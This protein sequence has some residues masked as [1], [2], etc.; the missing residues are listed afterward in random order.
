M[1]PFLNLAAAYS[2]LK[3]DIDCAVNRVLSSGQYIGGT[4]VAAFEEEFAAYCGAT[5]A[6]GVGNGL[7]ALHLALRAMGVGAGDEVIVP[8]NT[9]IATW[10]A[11]TM[12][13]AKPVPVEPDVGSFNLDP[14]LVEGAIT[15]R[16]RCILPVH[17]YGQSANLGEIYQIAEKHN[18]ATLEDAAQAHGATHSGIRVGG[19]SATVAWSFYPGKNLGAMGDAGAVTTNDPQ[20]AKSVKLLRNYGSEVKYHNQVAG[21]NSRLDPLQAAV[22]RVKLRHLD[23]WNERRSGLAAYYAASLEGLPVQL[24]RVLPGNTHIWHLYVIRTA[25]RDQLQDHLRRNGIESLIHYPVPPYAQPAYH[26]LGF[27]E[28]DFPLSSSIADTALSLP[29]G[30]HLRTADA[31]RVVATV[32]SFFAELGT[33]QSAAQR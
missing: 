16:T 30:P 29:I 3:T 21:Y 14:G 23:E 2:E 33:T 11:V 10:L 12:T 26:H 5:H 20:I 22:L 31:E 19:H 32:R 1:I 15:S 27:A 17:L 4:E 24:P 7:D 8:A 9:Y 25:Y 6:V 13:G 18:I 28:S